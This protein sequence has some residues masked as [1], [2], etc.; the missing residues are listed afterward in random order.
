MGNK[1]SLLLKNEK[2]QIIDFKNLNIDPNNINVIQLIT[3][4][5]DKIKKIIKE[6]NEK[7]K[8]ILNDLMLKFSF[9]NDLLNG[10]LESFSKRANLVDSQIISLESNIATIERLS[11]ENKTL[12]QENDQER[13][14]QI[15]IIIDNF[16]DSLLRNIDE[17][18]GRFTQEEVD[19][20]QF[21]KKID[22][23]KENSKG[24]VEEIEKALIS[25]SKFRNSSLIASISGF[26][27]VGG[28]T[29]I[30][31]FEMAGITSIITLGATS[32]TLVAP[33]IAPVIFTFFGLSMA[34]VALHNES[35]LRKKKMELLKNILNYYNQNIDFISE[36]MG[37]ITNS[38]FLELKQKVLQYKS[39]D[40]CLKVDFDLSL[41]KEQFKS[42]ITN[43]NI[44]KDKI[45]EM[46]NIQLVLIQECQEIKE[47][48]Q[49]IKEI[50][51]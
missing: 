8:M 36:V 25:Q 24:I 40:P 38:I 4:V 37:K 23:F 49:K 3:E 42:I 14:I 21:K 35:N 5:V 13:V 22:K 50:K 43:Q 51:Q 17:L 44:I 47:K 15:N 31:G 27:G 10:I 45:E 39:L 6:Q 2:N 48:S 18:P 46:T 33:V 28:A 41:I 7:E 20:E 1:N 34:C 32:I 26:L 9:N 11:S 12:I 30:G 19:D 29:V 16:I